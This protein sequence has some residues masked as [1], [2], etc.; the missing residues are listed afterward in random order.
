MC[1]TNKRAMMTTVNNYINGEIVPPSSN[2]YLDVIN[3]SDSS[4]IGKVG[5]SNAQDVD[6]AVT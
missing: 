1:I 5:L 3:P 4:I 6:C 2:E